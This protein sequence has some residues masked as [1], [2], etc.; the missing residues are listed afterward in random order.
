MK[1]TIIFAAIACVA[2]VSCVKNEAVIVSVQ[3]DGND[4]ITFTA[5]SSPATKTALAGEQTATY[6]L[7]TSPYFE[8][9]TAFAAWTETAYPGSTAPT[10]FMAGA[11]A[12]DRCTFDATLY[13]WKPAV[14]YYWPKNGYLTFAAFSP[15]DAKDDCSAAPSYSWSTSGTTG[16]LTIPEFT[17]KANIEEQYDLMYADREYNKTKA[18]YSITD[19][20][21]KD[22][23]NDTALAG[24]TY[25][26]N[27]VNLRFHHA[28]SSIVFKVKTAEDYATAIIKLTNIDLNNV[29]SK[30]TFNENITEGATYYAVPAWSAY[31]TKVSYDIYDDTTDPTT[32]QVVQYNSGTAQNVTLAGG[33]TAIILLPQDLTASPA[34]T[35]H[36]DYTIEQNGGAPV[37]QSAD[38]VLHNYNHGTGDAARKWVM[39]KRYTYTIVFGLDEIYFDPAVEAW[40]DYAVTGD[41]EVR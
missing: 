13:A 29:Y 6:D 24:Y 27:G 14:T 39:G 26:W 8:K 2:L 3:N 34:P 18:N 40:D 32:N 10:V 4:P 31:D 21:A 9:F 41:L 5:M 25:R 7:G 22:D 23:E 36:I 19:G 16:G 38:I 37:P 11:D 30:A 20:S 12:K 17:V 15:A 28:L 33:S 1:K 35:L